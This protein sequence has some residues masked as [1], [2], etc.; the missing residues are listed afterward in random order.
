MTA[1]GEFEVSLTP[2]TSD[3]IEAG[4][5]ELEKVF[6]GDL[7]GTSTGQMLSHRTSVPGSAGYVAIEHV[8]ATL[9]G[10]TGTFT[11]QHSSTM[12]KGKSQQSI[13]VVPDSGT[14]QLV[15]L[16]GSMEIVMTDG[17]HSY[18]FDYGFEEVS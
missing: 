4:R 5:M 11:L 13:T 3:A 7:D 2:A 14:G 15:G 10:K 18:R 12:S 16:S 17:S 6:R 8:S 9:A 1:T